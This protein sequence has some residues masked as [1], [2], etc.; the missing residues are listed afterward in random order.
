MHVHVNIKSSA[1]VS[2]P[3]DARRQIYSLRHHLVLYR[4]P[5]DHVDVLE[6]HGRDPGLDHGG[7]A[8]GVDDGTRSLVRALVEGLVVS[9]VLDALR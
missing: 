4:R 6:R 7:G 9:E 1:A 2:H 8:R 3:A 5:L